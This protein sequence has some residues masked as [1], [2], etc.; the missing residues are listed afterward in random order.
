MKT[1]HWV[2]VA[3]AIGLGA[4]V[5]ACSSKF[6]SCL[7]TRT[8]AETG[9]MAAGAAGD[10]AAAG[11]G[12]SSA[13]EDAGASGA[14]PGDSGSA[15]AGGNETGAS[16]SAGQRGGDAGAGGESVY[17]E[18]ECV[19]GAERFCQ[20]T[21][22]NCANGKQ[23][24]P[25]G[26][27]SAC[28]IAPKAQDACT[29]GDDA[30]CN[31]TPNEG[32]TCEDGAVQSCGPAAVGICKPGKSTCSGG[33]W[34]S[35]VGAVVAGT[36]LCASA[37]DNDCDGKADNELD[38]VC[39][40]SPTDNR[41]CNSHA[42]DGKGICHAGTQ[43]CAV[44]SNGASSHWGD[45]TGY[46]GPLPADRC[47][48]KGDDSNCDG[49][50]NGGCTCVLGDSS[51]CGQIYTSKGVC[52]GIALSCLSS[53]KWP[54]QAACAA[55]SAELCSA[56][57]KDE[58]CNGQVNE[59]CC[60]ALQCGV[61]CCGAAPPNTTPGCSG[62]ACTSLCTTPLSCSNSSGQHCGSWNFESGDPQFEGWRVDGSHPDSIASS[63]YYSQGRLA[64]PISTS[65]A[66]TLYLVT[67]LCS[68]GVTTNVKGKTLHLELSLSP[69]I[70]D[71]NPLDVFPNLRNP[72]GLYQVA[73][74]RFLKSS[75]IWDIPMLNDFDA[76]TL[77]FQ[78]SAEFGGYTG[79]L[80]L[81]NVSIK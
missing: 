19:I 5:P 74:D 51:T 58:N 57:G 38:N 13:N 52:A 4:Q 59:N 60:P 3:V 70:T 25:D 40:C 73:G 39:V 30:T 45:C 65:E 56:D 21:Q 24:C 7:D 6:S 75:L 23:T 12:G 67:T 26:M 80:Y 53:G 31:G 35:C 15:N 81:D 47:D 71:G 16:G 76:Q 22:G 54:T 78:V 43:T 11:H 77:D 44:A 36:R 34:G 42:G 63:L 29:P 41:T 50:K 9:G 18:R 55:T 33:S 69:P 66:A 68:A 62:Q 1:K 14:S 10:S 20:G 37:A 2:A 8:C 32:C 46:V 49:T 28:S 48:V 64:A 17:P 27:W 61:T 79:T 72:S